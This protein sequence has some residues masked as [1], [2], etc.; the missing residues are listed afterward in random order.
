MAKLPGEIHVVGDDV[1]D[2]YLLLANGHDG[3]TVAISMRSEA[4]QA[5]KTGA[6]NRSTPMALD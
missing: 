6:Q 2:K 3:N 5:V 4:G 1:S